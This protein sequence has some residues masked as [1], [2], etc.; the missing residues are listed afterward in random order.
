MLEERCIRCGDRV[1]WFS[2]AGNIAITI[3]KILVGVLGGSKAL[4]ADGLHS[5]T[6]VI[7]TSVIILTRSV[8]RTGADESHPFGHG[9]VEFMGSVFIYTVLILIAIAIFSGGLITIISGE[10][11]RPRVVTI[12]AAG[13]SVVY[14]VLMYRFGSCAGKRNNSPAL[15]ANAYENRADA[16]SSFAVI[17]GISGAIWI[18]PIIDPITAMIVGVIILTNSVAQLKESFSGLMDTAM[19]ADAVDDIRVVVEGHEGVAAVDF[20][21][22]RQ[23][24]PKFWVDLGIRVNAAFSVAQSDEIASTLRNKLMRRWDSFQN[25]VVFVESEDGQRG[26]VVDIAQQPKR[27]AEDK[28]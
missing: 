2:L 26:T 11:V 10:L 1:P 14:N 25:V 20:V 23:T 27:K 8:A 13:V 9:K 6:D 19:E 28:D 17:L 7:G 12:L 22:T 5:F 4:V 18:H 24:G 3:Y 21:R 15:M 16:V